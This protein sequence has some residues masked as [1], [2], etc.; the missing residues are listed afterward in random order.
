MDKTRFVLGVMLI[1][2]VP[3]AVLFWLFIHPI[4][5]FWRRVGPVIAYAVVGTLCGAI[6]VAVYHFRSEILGA[7]LGTSW[8]LVFLGAIPYAASAW[9]SILTKRHLKARIFVGL[10]EL[11]KSDSGGVLLQEGV[12]AVVRHPRYLSVIIGTTGFAMVVNYVGAYLMVLG[13]IPALFLVAIVE[14]RE[15]AARF[16]DDYEQYRTRVPA[17]IPRLPKRSEKRPKEGK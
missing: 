17:I 10:P 4:A 2:G 16:G 12:Y 1:V 15:L 3:P 6:A 8:I 9:I 13:T 5:G 7:D 11:S 14:E